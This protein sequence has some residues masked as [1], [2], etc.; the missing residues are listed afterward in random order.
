MTDP[1]D[2][3]RA[4]VEVDSVN[5]DLVPGGAGE[6]GMADLCA[7]WLAEHGFDVHRL[8]RRPGRPSVVGV[9]R[10]SGGG[11]SLML[12]GHLDTVTLAGY[13]GD[14]LEPVVRDGNVYGRGAFDMKGGLAAM[15]VAAAR[16][17]ATGLRGDVIV[18]CVADEE[19]GSAGTEEVL[20]AFTADGAVVTEPSHLEV[21]VA[22]QG[23]AWFEVEVEGVAAHGSRPD[24]G[25]DAIV[26]AGHLLVALAALGDRLRRGPGDPILGTGSVHAS[27]IDGGAEASSYPASCRITVERRTVPGEDGAAVEAE[28]AALVDEV[29]AAV[30]G[31]RAR[32]RRTLTRDPFRADVDSGV[33]RALLGQ[34]ERVTGAVPV[35]RGE[36]FWTDCALIA[37]AGIPCLLIGVDGGGAHAATEW[38][39]LA[40]LATVTDVIEGTV[41]EFCA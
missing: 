27:L 1:L 29:A 5:P 37:E 13:G 40:S 15:L 30:P 6:S 24:L 35:L 2:L 3:L 17:A 25:V 32:W 21:T 31:F 22:H 33:A 16:A 23:F 14:P 39:T 41:V 38:V 4:F 9:A 18:A 20:D 34:V 12:N 8:E 10:G 19:Y 26:H 7:A 11:R 36:P 28:M